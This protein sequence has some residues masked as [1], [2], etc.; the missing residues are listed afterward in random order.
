MI[1]GMWFHRPE[2]IQ[3]EPSYVR[4]LTREGGGW[5]IA[6]VISSLPVGTD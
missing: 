1:H 4:F 5:G 2:E 6:G 3:P